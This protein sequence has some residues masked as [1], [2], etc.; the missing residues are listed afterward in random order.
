MSQKDE[1]QNIENDNPSND[2][3]MEDILDIMGSRT[4]REIINLLR[5]EPRLLNI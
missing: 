1:N 5:E 3:D 2:V 4:R